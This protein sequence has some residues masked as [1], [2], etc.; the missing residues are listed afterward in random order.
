MEN[1]VI[2]YAL[3]NIFFLYMRAEVQIYAQLIDVKHFTRNLILCSIHSSLIY[4]NGEITF[5][6]V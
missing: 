3:F 1:Y 4:F 6:L 2:N 5:I